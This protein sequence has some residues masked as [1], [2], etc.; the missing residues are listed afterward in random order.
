MI[1]LILLSFKYQLVGRH[2]IL[3]AD[4]AQALH[5][6]TKSQLQPPNVFHNLDC[7]MMQNLRTTRA[8]GV[9]WSSRQ[10][11]NGAHARGSLL[12]SSGPKHLHGSSQ[13]AHLSS[14]PARPKKYDHEQQDASDDPAI[15]TVWSVLSFSGSGTGFGVAA[16]CRRWRQ[17]KRHGG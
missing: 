17:E 6:H 8:T 12:A 13:R 15:L 5:S 7:Y 11:T 4:L 1:L 9:A 16:P 3:N 10:R 14:S 2:L